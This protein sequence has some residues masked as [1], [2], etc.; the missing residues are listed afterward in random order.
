MMNETTRDEAN[1]T[2]LLGIIVA[3]IFQIG[4]EEQFVELGK[5]DVTPR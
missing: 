5:I 2:I 3:L 1:Q 4:K